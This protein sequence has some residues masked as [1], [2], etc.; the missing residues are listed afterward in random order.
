MGLWF[1]MNGKK[2]SVIFTLFIIFSFISLGLN[3]HPIAGEKIESYFTLVAKAYTGTYSAEY[4]FFVKEQIARIGINLEIILLDWPEFVAEFIAFRNFDIIS[5]GFEKHNNPIDFL[6]SYSDFG[7]LNVFGYHTDMDYDETLGTGKNEW[8]IRQGNLIM[9]PD[10]EERIQHYWNWE[11]YL[12]DRILPCQ[13]M[14]INSQYEAQWSNLQGYDYSKGILQSWGNM[15]WIGSHTGQISTNEIVIGDAPWSDL[16]PLFQDDASSRFISE[17][18]MDPLIWIDN[19]SSIWPHL[20]TSWTHIN[21]T[22]VR[23]TLREG[24]KW[25]TDP[26]GL[27][28][29]EYFDVEDV[30]FTYYIH[31]AYGEFPYY[32][33]IEDFEIIDKYTF[34]LYIDGNPDTPEN[35]PFAP[36]LQQI[37]QKILPEHYMNQSYS[38]FG[39][40][41]VTHESWN[42]FATNCFGTGLFELDSFTDGVETILTVYPECWYANSSITS[43]PDLDWV[44]RFGDFA[45]NIDRLRVREIDEFYLR[46]LEFEQGRIDITGL[47]GEQT[48]RGLYEANPDL[49][50]QAKLETAFN[51]IGYNMRPVRPVIGSYDPWILNESITRGLA[52]RKAISYAINREEINQIVHG[53]EFTIIDHPIFATQGIWCNPKIIKYNYDLEKAKFYMRNIYLGTSTVIEVDIYPLFILSEILLCLVYLLKRKK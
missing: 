4:L 37:S 32:N 17:A 5:Y 49:L 22:H 39:H 42:T 9:P 23:I 43:D 47:E 20:A 45:G 36:Y 46:L 40:P 28:P 30:Y 21:D 2:R 38:E 31:W 51:F 53:G 3:V 25:Q 18:T 33:W 15:D 13:P 34:D 24:I 10:S 52:I 50:V 6:S 44:N 35:E 29:N 41:D 16:N 19:D 11:Q 7:L 48:K 1:K 8:Y 14:M 27:F 12:M 26:D